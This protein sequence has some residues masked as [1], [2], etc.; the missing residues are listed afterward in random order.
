MS[1][2]PNEIPSG[3]GQSA[4]RRSAF[5]KAIDKVLG[6]SNEPAHTAHRMT[7]ILSLVIEIVIL[8]AVVGGK[9]G[10]TTWSTLAILLLMVAIPV[11]QI[12]IFRNYSILHTDNSFQT[13]LA[14]STC[15]TFAIISGEVGYILTVIGANHESSQSWLWWAVFD[16][17]YHG[18]DAEHLATALKAL[19]AFGAIIM[20]LTVIFWD[21]LNIYELRSLPDKLPDTATKDDRL[22]QKAKEISRITFILSDG[23][24]LA[25]WCSILSLI[26]AGKGRFTFFSEASAVDFLKVFSVLYVIVI[27]IRVGRMFIVWNKVSAPDVR[28]RIAF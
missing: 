10:D 21:V 28:R 7:F 23:L 24:A 20:K 14:V 4:R 26:L 18:W 25:I 27:G 2:N 12:F 15:L 16:E 3:T 17:P 22:I 11:H 8:Y 1:S 6:A 19:F 13:A 5:G 9:T